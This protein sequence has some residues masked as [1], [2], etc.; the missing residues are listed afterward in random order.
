MIDLYNCVVFNNADDWKDSFVN[1]Y[2]C[3][4][5]DNDIGVGG[6]VM[7]EN[8]NSEWDNSFV[9]YTNDDFRMLNGELAVLHGAGANKSGVW[10]DLTGEWQVGKDTV[11]TLRNTWDIGPFEYIAE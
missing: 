6:V 3:A 5:D 1:V 8:A 10:Q 11:G 2:N 9:D 4:S 7:E